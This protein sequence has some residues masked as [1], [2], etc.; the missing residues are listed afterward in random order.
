MPETLEPF[1]NSLRART[2]AL[3]GSDRGVFTY[4]FTS[5]AGHRPYFLTRGAVL[6]LNQRL[7]FPLWTDATIAAMPETHI[8]EW[9]QRYA[10]PMDKAYGT[11]LREGGVRA[12]G[13][14]VPGYTRDELSVLTVEEWG[15]QKNNYIIDAWAASVGARL[16]AK[17]K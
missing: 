3:R 12:L 15:S 16:P 1:F 4:G 6:W 2:Q 14:H 10:I 7:H 11:E 5:E 13:D 9:A 17:G 8:S